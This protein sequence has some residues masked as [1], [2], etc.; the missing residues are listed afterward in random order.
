MKFVAFALSTLAALSTVVGCSSGPSGGDLKG[1]WSRTDPSTKYAHLETYFQF[2][3]DAFVQMVHAT[4]R[5]GKQY[6]SCGR[7]VWRSSGNEVEI[8]LKGKMGGL[9]QDGQ[10]L[11]LK[12]TYDVDGDSMTFV[13]TEGSSTQTDSF[14]RKLAPLEVEQFCK[15]QF[16]AS[17]KEPAPC[18]PPSEAAA[19]SGWSPLLALDAAGDAP[20]RGF[21]VYRG[22]MTG[23]RLMVWNRVPAGLAAVLALF[24]CLRVLWV[25]RLP[26]TDLDAYG[27]FRIAAV[28]VEHPARLSAHWVWLPLY[29]YALAVLVRLGGS[30]A[31]ARILSVGATVLAPLV[32]YRYAARKSEP[33]ARLAALAF[34][35]SSVPNILGVSAQQ[36][37]WFALL[38][39]VT[40]AALD[41]R[42]YVLA[43]AAL[44]AACLV[45]Y[46]AWGAASLLAA[47]LFGACITGRK[48]F[49]PLWVL[50]GPALAMA[51]WLVWHRVEE[52]RWFAFL[53]ELYRF[54]HAQREGLHQNRIFEA[55]YFPLLL[56]LLLFGPA[57]VF[58]PLGL[59]RAVS[60]GWVIPCGIALFLMASYLGGGSLGATRY[61][62]S[63]AP[64]ILWA[65]AQATAFR[66][67]RRRFFLASVL[68]TSLIAMTRLRSEALAHAAELRRA[69]AT[70]AAPNA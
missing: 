56:P 30:L 40:S 50:V 44:G 29:H 20:S 34:A 28:L 11:V 8:Q 58:L 7:G 13:R 1:T 61:F 57:L 25:L 23:R 64:F 18:L 59:R 53:G 55:A 65:V 27:H 45:R 19:P 14:H 41:G 51:G 5:A 42:R 32:L 35:V 62:G 63:L 68:V 10:Y 17:G 70:L 4:D 15:E 26:E 36:E 6:V 38:V 39:L 43:S 21:S 22:S 47:A 3:S 31:T 54:T 66:A 16:A 12:S 37:S 9:D 49:A 67:A 69:E 33:V 60:P 24:C 52:G 48:A 2:D 46:E